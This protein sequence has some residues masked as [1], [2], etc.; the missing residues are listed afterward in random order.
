MDP[1]FIL[2]YSQTKGLK[3]K[4][5]LCISGSVVYRQYIHKCSSPWNPYWLTAVSHPPDSSP[6]LYF[7]LRCG[8]PLL[9]LVSAMAPSH[10]ANLPP[11]GLWTAL[12]SR[13]PPGTGVAPHLLSPLGRLC[14]EWLTLP[15]S[16]YCPT[17][18]PTVYPKVPYKKL[19]PV[20]IKATQF[21]YQAFEP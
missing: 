19:A 11:S 7:Y 8:S 9:S 12:P 17:S 15:E 13:S 16:E 3:Q 4:F 20:L 2:L 10:W 14:R 1:L 6:S 18:F 21:L 5:I